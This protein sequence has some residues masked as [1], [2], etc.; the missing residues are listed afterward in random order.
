MAESIA[1]TSRLSEPR[2]DEPAIPAGGPAV[3]LRLAP[4]ARLLAECRTVVPPAAVLVVVLQLATRHQAGHR[5]LALAGL[6]V[7]GLQVLPGMLL[8]R[9][10]RPA[11][12]WW[13]EDL[14]F[15]FA[16]GAALAIP[17]HVAAVAWSAP[18]LAWLVPLAVAPGLLAV[19]V[20]R[21]RILSARCEPLPRSWGLAVALTTVVPAIFAVRFFDQPLRWTGW[22][23]PYVDLPYHL[24]LT[25]QVA[26]Q[27]PLHYPQVAG[28]TLHYQWFSYAWIDQVSAT[29]GTSLDVILLRFMPAVIAIAVP[30]VTAAAAIRITGLVWAGPVAAAISCSMGE[31]DLPR[32]FTI[33]LPFTPFSPTQGFGLLLLVPVLALLVMRWR[34]EIP[35]A[36][37]ILVVFLLLAAGGSKGSTLPILFVGCALSA[38]AALA[39]R[40]PRRWVIIADTA[41][42]ALVLVALLRTLFGN[43]DGGLRVSPLEWLSDE[44]GAA[45]T[46]R[47]GLSSTTVLVVAVLTFVTLFIRMAA[48]L[49]CFADSNTRMDPVCWL[50]LGCGLAGAGAM[51]VFAHPGQSQLYF[52]WTATIPLSILAAWGCVALVARTARPG[53]VAV[54]GSVAGVLA[55]F[56]AHGWAGAWPGADSGLRSSV[57]QVLVF[58]ALVA[59]GCA[60]GM[61]LPRRGRLS[62]RSVVTA[63]LVAA[64][65]ASSVPALE[66]ALGS[67]SVDVAAKPWQLGAVSSGEVRAARWLRDNS[68]ESDLVMTNR[69]CRGPEHAG[70]DHRTF[71]VSA[72]SERQVLVEGWAYTQRA[73]ALHAGTPEYAP[74]NGPFWRPGLLALN[75][76][77]FVHPTATAARRLYARGVRWVYVDRG[78]PH[79]GDLTRYAVTRFAT[80]TATVYELLAAH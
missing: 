19:P 45:L 37:V 64:T 66:Y 61:A 54:A 5:E 63:A 80:P 51:V 40:S 25:G 60:V 49:V 22:A 62:A 57:F 43:S 47:T 74:R 24:A 18:V 73:N 41:V 23:K 12:G 20:T 72:Y 3:Q 9:I 15:G 27:W 1:M 31:L 10:I 8:W 68:S 13:I 32:L 58:A 77:F 71:F 11:S 79:T 44:R 50:L 36:A 65:I 53:V 56:V 34:A 39:F 4:R 78:A 75:D 14:T 35:K 6:T 2:H 38:L 42:V 29:S 59:A 28:E 55:V 46:G 17:A 48:A 33:S 21:R 30:L 52:L 69:H 67:A 76:R 7:L 16:V 26:H 70:C